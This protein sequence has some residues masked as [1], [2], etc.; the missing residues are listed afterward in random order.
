[1]M[2]LL[3]NHHL[4]KLPQKEDWYGSGQTVDVSWPLLES[5]VYQN[6]KAECNKHLAPHDG[7]QQCTRPTCTYPESCFS[8]PGDHTV[9][10]DSLLEYPVVY[11]QCSFYYAGLIV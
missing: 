7:Q 4:G 1:M 11:R 2:V 5:Q 9:T 6:S 3:Q 8:L 10:H